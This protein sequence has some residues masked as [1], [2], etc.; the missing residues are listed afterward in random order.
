MTNRNLPAEKINR[1]SRGQIKNTEEGVQIS[2]ESK[3]SGK[4]PEILNIRIDKANN[5]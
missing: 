2:K 4:S 1:N 3:K 5:N